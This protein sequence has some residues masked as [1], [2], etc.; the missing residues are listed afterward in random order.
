MCEKNIKKILMKLKLKVELIEK[1]FYKRIKIE[2]CYKIFLR[3]KKIKN[4]VKIRLIF[5][6]CISSIIFKG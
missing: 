3:E 1:D 2:S 6:L 5:L 4:C